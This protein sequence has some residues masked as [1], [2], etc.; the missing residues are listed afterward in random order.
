MDVVIS[1]G[2]INSYRVNEQKSI[3]AGFAKISHNKN[4]LLVKTRKGLNSSCCSTF[5]VIQVKYLHVI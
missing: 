1:P 3:D 5:K 4:A 2:D